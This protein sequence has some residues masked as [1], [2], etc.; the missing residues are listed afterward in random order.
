MKPNQKGRSGGGEIKGEGKGLIPTVSDI[1][2]CRITLEK[3]ED[4]RLKSFRNNIHVREE[5]HCREPFGRD[6]FCI[7]IYKLF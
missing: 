2:Y 5:P 7:C 4:E 1:W 6:F 3:Q